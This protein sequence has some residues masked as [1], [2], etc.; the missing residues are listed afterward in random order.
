MSSK[1]AEASNLSEV[2][3]ERGREE[4]RVQ[5]KRRAKSKESARGAVVPSDLVEAFEARLAKLELAVGD[6]MDTLDSREEEQEAM[7]EEL[8]GAMQGA[9]NSFIDSINKSMEE[10]RGAIAAEISS[11]KEDVAICKA[12]VSAGV[13]TASVAPKIKVPE[14]PKFGGKRDA[15]EL[16]NF[17]WLVEQYL[18]ALNVVDDATKIKT[19]TLY[20]EHDA[21]LWWRRRHAEME[22]GL[23]EIRT[24]E[25]FKGELKKQFYPENAEEVAMKKLRGLKHTG[26]LR[27][28]F[29]SIPSLM[30]EIPDMPDKSRLLYFLD[31]LQRWAEQTEAKGCP[32]SCKRNCG[33]RIIGGIL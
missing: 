3:E 23:V 12:A 31:G 1:D 33:G 24:W 8:E 15:K 26:S 20:L 16:D 2:Q 21:I 11:L 28:T 27:I 7:K 4:A 32:R 13:T 5:P 30:L 25:A 10:F 18:D 6:I 29:G 14:P 22:R 9:L 17:F 19:T